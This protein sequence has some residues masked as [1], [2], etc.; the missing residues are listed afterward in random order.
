MVCWSVLYALA[1]GMVF[2]KLILKY[3]HSEREK[4]GPST[5]FAL[6]YVQAHFPGS[7][8]GKRDTSVLAP[9]I[10]CSV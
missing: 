1:I 2:S 3:K 9:N 5:V 10:S 6:W 4:R 7:S 8:L